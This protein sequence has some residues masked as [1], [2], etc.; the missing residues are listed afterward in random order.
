MK[1]FLTVFILYFGLNSTV[2]AQLSFFF[3]EANSFFAENVS[4]NGEVDYE[5]I[6]SNPKALNS[7]VEFI[8]TADL[9]VSKNEKFAF[10][11]NAYNILTI[12]QVVDN[13]PIKSPLDVDGFFDKK[14]FQVSYKSMTLNEIENDII[15]PVY[16][17]P[18]IHFALVCAALSCPPIRPYAFMPLKV[19]Q[20]LETV[21]K[22]ALNNT[23]FIKVD[24]T[25]KKVQTSMIF[26]WYMSDFANTNKGV[27]EYINKY[28]TTPI[29]L[30]YGYSN[31]DYNW[32]LNKKKVK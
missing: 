1:V 9:K 14:K 28:R 17:D 23:E 25:G 19:D 4:A 22:K 32:T 3:D 13:Y 20:Q 12:K 11:L 30:D 6:K 2:F 21:T 26:N 31:Y 5:S 27:I 15:R 7:L 10:Y 29:P 24:N 18:R 8:S 16:Q